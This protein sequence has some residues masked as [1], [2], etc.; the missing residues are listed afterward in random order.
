MAHRVKLLVV[1][2][3]LALPV[4]AAAQTV[5]EAVV[6]VDEASARSHFAQ[7]E[8]ARHLELQTQ[9][10]AIRQSSLIDWPVTEIAAGLS[11]RPRM[12]NLARL[13][14]GLASRR[15][16]LAQVR[17]LDEPLTGAGAIIDNELTGVL[18]ETVGP[19]EAER[20]LRPWT[21][22]YRA[23]LAQ[24]LE[25]S[26]EKLRRYE[27]KFGPG[28]ARLNG[29]ELVANYALQRVRHFGPDERGWPGPLEVVAA[30]TPTYVTVSEGSAHFVSAGELGLRRY[31]FGQAWGRGGLK[32]VVRPAFT[33]LGMAV[34]NEQ[35]G[36][37]RW[38]WSGD[39]RVGV[40]VSWGEIK[41]AYVG[42]QARRVLIS[43]QFQLVPWVF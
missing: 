29:V 19:A 7:R 21:A 31:F 32:G 24:S 9:L 20:V 8:P 5:R 10:E 6:S 1:G 17:A 22:L 38:P 12:A 18:Q 30:Y 41:V 36:A 4:G 40:F 27:R 33:T 3:V 16:I 35:D 14:S 25:D 43:R 26:L 13:E 28:S 11:E 42:G 15:E 39:P 23:L 37:L 34:A 2:F